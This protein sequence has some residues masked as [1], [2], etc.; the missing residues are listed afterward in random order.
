MEGT[1]RRIISKEDRDMSNDS[2]RSSK[3]L[4][5]SHICGRD[6]CLSTDFAHDNGNGRE[7]TIVGVM[8]SSEQCSGRHSLSMVSKLDTYTQG[9][10]AL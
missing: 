10:G 6:L 9:L 2:L 3:T 1:R 4:I 8:C 5:F 7:R